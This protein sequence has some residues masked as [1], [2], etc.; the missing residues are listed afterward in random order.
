MTETR[1]AEL[2]KSLR[3]KQSKRQVRNGEC[4]NDS[5]IRRKH[6]DQTIHLKNG[7]KKLAHHCFR[8]VY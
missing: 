7:K 8:L 4:G 5:D 6:W 1:A 3:E 2:R